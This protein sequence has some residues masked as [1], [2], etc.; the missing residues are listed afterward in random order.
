[1]RT[2]QHLQTKLY[3]FF[4]SSAACLFLGESKADTE[5]VSAAFPQ[6]DGELCDSK[7][8]VVFG[9]VSHTRTKISANYA[10]PCRSMLAIKVSFDRVCYL[11][12]APVSLY[13]LHCLFLCIG[14]HVL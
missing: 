3:E 8:D 5:R 6:E 9:F 4:T 11:L 13:S 10:I 7:V 12:L 1:M 2:Q 14:S